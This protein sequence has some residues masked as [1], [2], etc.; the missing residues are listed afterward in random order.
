MMRRMC[1]LRFLTTSCQARGTILLVK[2]LLPNGAISSCATKVRLGAIT[3][4]CTREFNRPNTFD[5][6][7]KA[8]T[9][10][11]DQVELHVRSPIS[12]YWRVKATQLKPPCHL[13][14]PAQAKMC[15][16]HP[17]EPPTLK[18]N[19]MALRALRLLLW[20]LMS[21]WCWRRYYWRE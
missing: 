18:L 12:S 19:L 14:L 10:F 5:K 1:S 13:L 15:L 2:K 11:D 17:S 8:K 7:D 16:N 3:R 9:R 20:E 4:E 21:P 6:S